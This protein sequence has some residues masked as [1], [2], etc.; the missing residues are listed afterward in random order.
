MERKLTIRIDG[1]GVAAGKIAL[2]DL[3]RI[4]HPLEQAVR[5]LLPRLPMGSAG[6]AGERR[7]S[8]QFLLSGIADGS[9]VAEGSLAV[10][11]SMAESL[12]D[13]DPFERLVAGISDGG[14]KLPSQ[15]LRCIERLR[16]NLPEGVETVEIALSGQAGRV[17]LLPLADIET[18]VAVTERRTLSGRL[19]EIDFSAKRAKLEVPAVK[20]RKSTRKISLRFADELAGDM[21]RL[22]RQLVAAVGLATLYED[23]DVRE[24]D[25]TGITLQIDDRGAL[26]PPKRFKWP[27]KD[28]LLSNV[29]M[30]EFLRTSSDY[31]DEDEE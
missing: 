4:V 18:P 23:G 20:G 13:D 10:E 8:V 24:L 15:A 11:A 21:Q 2:R 19:V 6:A 9:A 1:P 28:Q 14:Q 30:E 17:T 5:A 26:W 29:D 16:R 3:Q 31:Y 25:V 12:F 7:Q 22:A 27:T